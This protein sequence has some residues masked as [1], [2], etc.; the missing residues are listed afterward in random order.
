MLDL[1]CIEPAGLREAI[2]DARARSI[3][4]LAGLSDAQLG[5]PPRLATINPLLWEVGHVAW[6]QE[7]W[8]CR[9]GGAPSLLAEADALFDSIAIPHEVRWRLPLPDRTAT[10]R[11]VDRCRDRALE[12]LERNGDA[13]EELFHQLYAV[14]HEDMHA[15]A[16]SYTRQTLAWPWPLRRAPPPHGDVPVTGDVAI[17]GGRYHLGAAPQDGFVFDNEKW[18]APIHVAPFRIA[19]HPVTQ[20]EFLAFV[21]ADGYHRDDL[22]SPAGRAWRDERGLRHPVYWRATDAGYQR[23]SFDRWVALEPDHPVVFVS[24]YEAEAYCRFANRRLPDEAEWEM[25]ALSEGSGERVRVHPWG[26]VADPTRLN[27]DGRFGD[28]VSVHAFA[29]GDSPAGCRQML[30]NVW[31][32]TADWFAPL[33]GFTPD[34]YASYSQISFHFTRVL[35][36]GSFMTG[37]RVARAGYRNFFPPTRNDVPAGFRTCAR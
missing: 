15:E 17:D 31:E 14:L 28:T 33:P 29:E 27:A 4:L 25:A 10:L 18:R 11:Y 3:A 12:Q 30:G 9:R 19:R 7:Y 26:E 23:R 8:T 35:K 36:G 16:F 22:W 21:E 6:F 1:R 20:A 2:I 32:W 5:D 13:A 37:S 34:P 24:W